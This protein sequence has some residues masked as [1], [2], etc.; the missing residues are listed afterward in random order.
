[1][2]VPLGPMIPMMRLRSVIPLLPAILLA[3]CMVQE[4]GPGVPLDEGLSLFGRVTIASPASGNTRRAR[5]QVVLIRDRHAVHGSITRERGPL[6]DVRRDNRHAIGFLIRKGFLLLGCEAALGPLPDDDGPAAA[7]REAVRE[8]LAEGDRLHDLTV[9]QP[10]RYEEEFRNVLTVLGM[11]DPELYKTDAEH[12]ERILDLRLVAGRADI[13]EDARSAAVRDMGVH[14]EEISRNVRKRGHAAACNLVE[15]M[16][17]EG[18]DRAMLMLG[19]AHAAGALAA[20]QEAG[21]SVR[22]FECES[23][24]KR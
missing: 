19:G 11:E 18:I 10:I 24:Q 16:L 9:Y 4:P 5:L 22:I 21:V 6:R 7:H 3:G 14:M 20:F 15:H 12:L 1:M 2:T 8:A 23:Y 13:P 17:A